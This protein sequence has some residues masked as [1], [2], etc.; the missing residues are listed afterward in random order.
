MPG[1]R[2]LRVWQES[3]DLSVAIYRLT[4]GLPRHENYGLSSQMRRAAVSI[5]ANLA[6]GNAR[7]GRREYLH[8]IS[9]AHGSL[10][11]LETYLELCPRLDYATQADIA[12]PLAKSDGIGRQ[13]T[14]LKRALAE[15]PAIYDLGSPTTYGQ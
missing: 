13:L 1:F 4:A 12:P 2:D 5:P 10:S 3:M 8:F 15:D 6:E 7:R 14:N 9:I 11:E